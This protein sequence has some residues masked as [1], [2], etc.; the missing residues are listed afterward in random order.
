MGAMS[1]TILELYDV[2]TVPE[3][4][5]HGRT[6]C[7]I[8]DELFEKLGV[9]LECKKSEFFAAYCE[10]LQQKMKS[11]G[12]VV[13][14]AVVDV[15]DQLSFNPRVSLGILTGNVEKAAQIKL[16]HF[17]LSEYFAFGGYGDNSSDRNDVAAEAKEKAIEHLGE[18]F[19]EGKVWVIG[20]TRN[21]VRCAHS[22]KAKALAVATGGESKKQLL[23]SGP[24][25]FLENLEQAQKWVGGF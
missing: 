18:Q 3:I 9:D 19:E 24:D 1:Q 17:G 6:D 22:I 8:T 23:E 4:S 21:D 2:E 5:V 20:D 14:P 10:R 13:L 12:G 15:L 11:S 25:L 16:N 7:G